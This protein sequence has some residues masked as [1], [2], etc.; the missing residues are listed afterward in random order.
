MKVQFRWVAGAA[1]AAALA[2]GAQAQ[3]PV[4]LKLAY[5]VGDQHAMSQWL[6]KWADDIEKDSGGRIV[7]KRFPGAQ[8]GPMQQHYDFVRTGQADVAWFL[9]G[10]TPGRF[11]LT[12]IINCRSGRQ[13]RDR[14]QGA[15]R[16]RIAR[17]ISRRRAQGRQGADAFHPPARQH[18]YHQEADQHVDDVK[19]MRLRFAS[20]KSATSSRRSAVRRSACRRPNQPSRC[21]RARSTAWSSITAAPGSLSRS[22]ARS[23]TRP[24]SIPTCE[25]RPRDERGLLEQ[26][27]ARSAA[28]GN[29]V[30]A[31]IEKEIGQAWDGLDAPGKKALLDGGG[32]AIKFSRRTAPS[33]ARSA[34]EVSGRQ[35]QG[36][37]RQGPARQRRLRRR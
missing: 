10:A 35:G 16:P 29:Q 2:A 31:G 30:V 20:P 17:E 9:H 34:T 8:M 12:E 28:A 21:R 5:Y 18:P 19:G 37:R 36:T 32:E 33:S 4:E 11:P 24:R 25:L 7:V 26:A 1:L 3:Q 6:I 23:S 13:R 14:H 27:A 15:E 22:A